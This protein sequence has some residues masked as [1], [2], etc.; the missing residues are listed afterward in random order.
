[1]CHP[2]QHIREK[3]FITMA[4]MAREL[5]WLL[6]NSSMI[7]SMVHGEDMQ[8]LTL[9]STSWEKLKQAKQVPAV[10]KMT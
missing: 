3:H 1:M 6:G 4:Q 10:V 9:L 7:S 5:Y 2:E 8:P